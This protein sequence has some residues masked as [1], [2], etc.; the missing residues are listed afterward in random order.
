[1]V[2]RNK[3]INKPYLEK[4]QVIIY[5][6]FISNLGTA[7]WPDTVFL[8]YKV[9]D[10]EAKLPNIINIFWR[11]DTSLISVIGSLACL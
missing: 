4:K 3:N 7:I 11:E 5:V 2:T 10:Y 6:I 8:E 9:S 1:M